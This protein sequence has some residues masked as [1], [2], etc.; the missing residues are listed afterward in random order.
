MYDES[1]KLNRCKKLLE[2]SVK[3]DRNKEPPKCR[4]CQ[5]YQPDFRYRR[6]I[7]SSCPYGKDRNSAFRKN[8][9]RKEKF[10]GKEGIHYGK[11]QTGKSK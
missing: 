5:Y 4:L 2:A 7:F 1:A 11:V 3:T 9:L 8:P 6:C 10:I